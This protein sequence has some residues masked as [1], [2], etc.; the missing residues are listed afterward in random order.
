MSKG[1]LDV[2]VHDARGVV[3]DLLEKLG[4]PNGQEWLSAAKRFLRKEQPWPGCEFPTFTLE[5]NYDQSIEKSLSVGGYYQTNPS[6]T[7][8]NFPFIRSGVKVVRFYLVHFNEAMQNSAVTRELEHL[9]AK[10]D[11]RDNFDATI[12]ELLAFGANHETRDFQRRFSIVAR[13]SYWR[14]PHGDRIVP[15][16]SGDDRERFVGLTWLDDTWDADCRFLVV[17]RHR[18][19]V[20]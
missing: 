13:G 11:L 6:L 7:S 14:D 5:V 17:G 10:L 15:V 8:R 4:G 18:K 16:L 9:G 1:M 2:S 19:I 3:A 12:N 20:L